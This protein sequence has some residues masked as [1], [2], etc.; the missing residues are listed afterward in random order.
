MATVS[1]VLIINAKIKRRFVYADLRFIK[2]CGF[3][4]PPKIGCARNYL[5]ILTLYSHNV[6]KN[7]TKVH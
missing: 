4:Y 2:D 6:N 7:S 5:T 1:I 3:I